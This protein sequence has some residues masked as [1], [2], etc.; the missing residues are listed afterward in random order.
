MLG[1]QMIYKV[2]YGVLV[3]LIAWFAIP[4]AETGMS[5]WFV[6]ALITIP[7]IFFDVL[8]IPGSKLSQFR[9]EHK[10]VIALNVISGLVSVGIST[11][12]IVWWSAGYK[13]W[14]LGQFFSSLIQYLGYF[15]FIYWKE[16]IIPTFRFS[17]KKVWGYM[18]VA[19]P[20]TNYSTYLLSASDR[21]LLDW[22]AVPALRLGQYNLAYSFAGLFEFLNSQI[23][24]VLSPILFDLYSSKTEAG[25]K[26]VQRLVFT[27]FGVNVVLSSLLSLWV[28]DIFRFLY[29]KEELWS[30]YPLAILVLFGFCYRPIYVAPVARALLAR[31]NNE[32]MLMVFTAATACV[33]LNLITIPHF[34]VWASAATTFIGYMLMGVL[35]YFM[36]RD[37]RE[38]RSAYR[39]VLVYAAFIPWVVAFFWLGQQGIIIR[40]IASAGVLILAA[41]MAKRQIPVLRQDLHVYRTQFRGSRG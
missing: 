7:A 40:L 38:I 2:A 31:R 20:L 35:G 22:Y 16:R 6:L 9:G 27:W 30:A 26:T 10:R 3:G 12:A 19:V 17:R 11:T 5:K 29:R 23:N 25:K 41:I 28:A 21:V 18:S 15:Y 8:K 34:H 33:V 1:F 39:P 24:T 14:L 37:G 4:A 13:G 36:M 32:R